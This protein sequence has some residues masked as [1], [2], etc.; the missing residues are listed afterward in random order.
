MQFHLEKDELKLLADVLLEQDVGKY[1][2]ILN[3]VLDR[4]LR[5][6]AGELEQTAELLASK[7][8]SL[9]DEIARQ[10]NAVLKMELQ[11]QLALLER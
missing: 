7:K 8:R 11:A 2:E 10:P 4:D 6:D 5:F 9:K 3:K 1:N